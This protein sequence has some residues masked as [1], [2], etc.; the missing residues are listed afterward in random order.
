MDPPRMN[1]NSIIPVKENRAAKKTQIKIP[2]A[3]NHFSST[4]K[5]SCAFFSPG[6]FI[7]ES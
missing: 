6:S 7:T 1:P 5:A 4:A 2:K 3:I